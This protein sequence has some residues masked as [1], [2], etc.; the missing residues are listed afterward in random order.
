MAFTCRLFCVILVASADCLD[1]VMTVWESVSD[2]LSNLGLLNKHA[3]SF[4]LYPLDQASFETHILGLDSYSFN[5]SV[6][7]VVLI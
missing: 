1:F 3:V 2:L 5:S 4:K 6:W 7:I